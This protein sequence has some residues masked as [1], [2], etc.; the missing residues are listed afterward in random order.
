MSAHSG[1]TALIRSD[2][3]TNAAQCG[4]RE[5]GRERE[6]ESLDGGLDRETSRDKT[7]IRQEIKKEKQHDG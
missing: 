2:A 3:V 4:P 1:S 5:R 6:R 7:R